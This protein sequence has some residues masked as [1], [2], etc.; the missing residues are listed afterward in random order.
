MAAGGVEYEIGSAHLVHLGVL[1]DAV[2]DGVGAVPEVGAAAA[3]HAVGGVAARTVKA[4][5]AQAPERVQ[6]D[7]LVCD[8][9]YVYVCG[10]GLDSAVRVK[11][12]VLHFSPFL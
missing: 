7:C 9:M 4:H 2:A 8:G 1:P 10:R 6:F 11:A 12:I 5:K 3:R